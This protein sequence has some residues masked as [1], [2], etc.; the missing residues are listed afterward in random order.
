MT[1][2]GSA[3]LPVRDPAAAAA[4]FE[5]A[6]DLGR[7]SVDEWSAVLVDADG[8]RLTLL[9]PASGVKAQ[10]GLPWATHNLVVDDLDAVHARLDGEGQPV[11][12]LTGDPGV[13]RFFTVP[14]LDG[15]LL[16]VVDR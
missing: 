2:I 3:F 10:P 13:C 7:Q 15:N 12:E 5:R 4:W 9:G 8:G 16:L 14:D 11:T 1:R 6:F